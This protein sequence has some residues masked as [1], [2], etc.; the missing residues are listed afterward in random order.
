M[1]DNSILKPFF[2]DIDQNNDFQTVSKVLKETV[3]MVLRHS[4]KMIKMVIALYCTVGRQIF[5]WFNAMKRLY[6]YQSV[7]SQNGRFFKWIQNKR[8]T[9]SPSEAKLVDVLWKKMVDLC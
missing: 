4:Q 1:I 5:D 7:K 8:P 2:F 3:W 9:L 6:V